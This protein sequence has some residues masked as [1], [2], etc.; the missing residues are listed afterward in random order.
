MTC[1][2]SQGQRHAE[3]HP[4]GRTA[5][6]SALPG[7][8]I[9]ARFFI[10]RPQFPHLRHRHRQ[11]SGAAALVCSGCRNRT[12]PTGLTPHR[13]TV[14]PLGRLQSQIKVSAGLVPT[15]AREG[16]PGPGC[17]PSF[18]R[19]AEHLCQALFHRLY[20]EPRWLLTPRRPDLP[21]CVGC[22]P[23]PGADWPLAPKPGADSQ[24]L[25][26]RPLLLPSSRDPSLSRPQ[27][28]PASVTPAY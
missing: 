19:F 8:W 18:W 28:G 6:G 14:S 4:R 17:L 21:P 3:M 12:S 27:L 23:F 20:M 25:A 22:R 24:H 11:S 13:R 1:Q 7:A 10:S 15:E 9:S 5:P 26:R 16:E 2:S